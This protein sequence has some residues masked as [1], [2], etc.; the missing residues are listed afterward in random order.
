MNTAPKRGAF[1]RLENEKTPRRAPQG[2]EFSLVED[3]TGAHPSHPLYRKPVTAPKV[4]DQ[5][6]LPKIRRPSGPAVIIARIRRRQVD[7]LVL[8]RHHGP[9]L[10]DEGERYFDVMAVHLALIHGGE[11]FDLAAE[12]W[13]S[14]H[15]PR[16]SAAY[17]A[18]GI[19]RARGSRGYYAS[20][21][22]GRYLNVTI[23]EHDRLRLTH[24][25]PSDLSPPAFKRYLAE[26]AAAR[27][28]AK[29]LKTGKTTTPREQSASQLKPWIAA[30]FNTRRTW[31]RHGKPTPG[32]ST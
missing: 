27:R 6:P 19:E 21:D 1:T 8:D 13:A 14:L 26:R 7:A 24:I 16:L 25:A 2:L 17:V 28:K 9:C 30:G 5:L 3:N 4:A 20:R 23:A 12:E 22:V 15:T 29:R 31:E 11:D 18:E 10:T 32:S